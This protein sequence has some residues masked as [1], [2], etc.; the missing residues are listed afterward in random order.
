MQSD[1]GLLFQMQKRQLNSEGKK[2]VIKL[3]NE[4]DFKSWQ[5]DQNKHLVSLL[6]EQLKS[7]NH[8]IVQL[9]SELESAIKS[10]ASQK[11]VD[12]EQQHEEEELR[13][14]HREQVIMLRMKLAQA[15]ETLEQI[16]AGTAN[17]NNT[18]TTR[19]R[20]FS[21]NTNEAFEGRSRSISWGNRAADSSESPT[22]RNAA[23]LLER[24]TALQI[25]NEK[26]KKLVSDC[27]SVLASGIVFKSADQQTL[28]LPVPLPNHPDQLPNSLDVLVQV[29][30]RLT[31]LVQELLGNKS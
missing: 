10:G 13:K 22:D 18:G 11:R 19:T 4:L 15:E 20:R 12:Q 29:T 1:L 24:I 2:A 27:C 25:E 6:Q 7:R 5:L 8:R 17:A 31:D 30:H 23:I 14:R 3:R 28:T 16:R 9:E 21:H 26:S